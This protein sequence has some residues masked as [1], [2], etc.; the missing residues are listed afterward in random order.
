MSN[1]IE[2][3]DVLRGLA[4]IGVV[5]I[6]SSTTGFQFE[7]H[8]F[9]FNFTVVWRNL[10]N[11]SVPLFLAISGYF[12]AKKKIESLDDYLAFIKKYIARVY[13]PFFIWSF[14]WFS[15]IFNNYLF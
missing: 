1:R 10:L 12:L 4:I 8:S 3:F 7:H 6:H 2:Y 5:A 14:A 11:F 13:I 15:F 9:N